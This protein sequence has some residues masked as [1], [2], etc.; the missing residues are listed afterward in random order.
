MTTIRSLLLAGCAVASGVAAT[1]PID[2]SGVLTLGPEVKVALADRDT[3]ATQWVRVGDSFK[4]YIVGAFDSTTETVGLSKGALELRLPLKLAKILD[5]AASE[6]ATASDVAQKIRGNLHGLAVAAARFFAET[7]RPQAVLAD[8]VGPGKYLE[9]LRPV[10]GEDY[11]A[12][13]LERAH[14]QLSL[15]TPEGE[16]VTFDPQGTRPTDSRF[17]FTKDGDSLEAIAAAAGNSVQRILEL[18]ELAEPAPIRA[19]RLLRTH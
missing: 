17:H 19:G 12:V 5:S 7:G 16:I 10:A 11:G 6:G 4:G 13:R 1:P 9:V 14:G 2:F 15:T 8:L 18:N 3:G